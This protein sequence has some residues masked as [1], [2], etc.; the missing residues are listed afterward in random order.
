MAFPGF[1]SGV[2]VLCLAVVAGLLPFASPSV[3]QNLELRGTLDRSATDSIETGAVGTIPYDPISPG[4]LPFEDE[5]D[6]EPD[7][8]FGGGEISAD[9]LEETPARPPALSG[10]APGA[11]GNPRMGPVSDEQPQRMNQRIQAVQGS[12]LRRGDNPYAPVGFRIGTFSL[13]PTVEQGL[14][15]TSNATNS[16][17]G[18]EALLSETRLQLRGNSDWS[19]HR[20][21][22]NSD[23]TYENAISGDM[24][25]ELR[26]SVQAALQLDISHSLTGNARIAYEAER[27]SVNSPLAV[28]GVDRQPIRHRLTGELGLEKGLGP[29]RLAATGQLTRETYGAAQLSD[30]TEISQDDRS[31]T[32]AL[33]RLR[34]GYELSPALVPFVE[35]EAGRRT[36]DESHDSAGYERSALRLGARAGVA[37]DIAEKLSGEISAGWLSEDFDDDRLRTLSG[38]ALAASL[39]WSPM[40]G[41]N[42]F[43]DGSTTVEGG[44]GNDSGSLLYTTRLRLEHELRSNLTGDLSFGAAW[45]DYEAGGHDLTLH[46]QASLTWWLNRYAGLVSRIRHERRTSSDE[47]R[48]YDSSSIFV[49]MKFQ[50]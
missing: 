48:E 25:P 14:T 22:F 33:A 40:R 35:V 18:E 3:G 45:R 12:S 46:G 31:S 23:L 10:S 19:R 27:E 24:E 44:S 16:P 36:Y 5:L 30:G 8:G 47:G 21:D 38:L 4:A 29:L 26:G 39:R 41:T 6:I 42:V 37:V 49:G 11:R 7:A 13:F 43:F 9:E 32:L 17:D 34:A 2:S 15:A 28:T 20:L 50:R 1:Y